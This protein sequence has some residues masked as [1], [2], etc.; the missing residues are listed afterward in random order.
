MGG[1]LQVFDLG[2]GHGVADQIALGLV[3]ALGAQGVQLALGLDPFGEDLQPDGGG[4]VA[5]GP[6]DRR[7]ILALLQEG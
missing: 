5:D 2:G 6:D 3:A 1:G 7:S 4:Q